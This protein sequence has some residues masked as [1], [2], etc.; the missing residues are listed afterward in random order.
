M[1][2]QVG[3]RH[4]ADGGQFLWGDGDA[5]VAEV[6]IFSGL[7]LTKDNFVCARVECDDV[8]FVSTDSDVG[9]DDLI[10]FIC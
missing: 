1:L 3:A 7:Y 9:R 8:H 6:V 10:A 4:V 5:G 2:S